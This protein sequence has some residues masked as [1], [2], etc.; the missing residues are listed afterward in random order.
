MSPN[1]L[2]PLK[3]K[4]VNTCM[5]AKE[6]DETWLWHHRFDQLH[7]N[8]LRTLYEKKMVIGL[9]KIT[10]QTKVCKECVIA[11]QPRETFPSG[12]ATRAHLVLELVRSDLC[13]PTNPSSNGG[14]RYFI[15]FIDDFSRKTW[16]YFLHKKSEACDACKS[17]KALVENESKKKIKCLCTD[18]G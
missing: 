18:R 2:F 4:S 14:K 7:F 8:R 9:P 17:F 6:N 1:R 3:L 11:K 5:V 13:G 12:K 16:V 15:S 10:I